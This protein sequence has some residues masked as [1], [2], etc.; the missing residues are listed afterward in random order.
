MAYISSKYWLFTNYSDAFSY[1]QRIKYF[2]FFFFKEFPPVTYS[3]PRHLTIISNPK[4]FIR[5]LSIN[6]KSLDKTSWLVLN[7]NRY[8]SPVS[9]ILELFLDALI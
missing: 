2:L 5:L 3:F 4:L 8:S 7:F 1:S 6:S 9:V